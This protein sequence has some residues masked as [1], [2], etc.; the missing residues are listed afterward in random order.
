[1]HDGTAQ[2]PQQYNEGN[3]KPICNSYCKSFAMHAMQS[4]SIATALWQVCRSGYLITFQNIFGLLSSCD[5]VA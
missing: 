2:L 1:M 5:H 3:A 4:E